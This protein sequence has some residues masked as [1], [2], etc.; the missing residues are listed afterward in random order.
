MI[1]F[2]HSINHEDASLALW[3]L[4]LKLKVS[5]LAPDDGTINLRGTAD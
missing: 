1:G 5:L 2:N 3:D 4:C